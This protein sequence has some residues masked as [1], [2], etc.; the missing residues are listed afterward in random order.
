MT[1][2]LADFQSKTELNKYPVALR[3]RGGIGYRMPDG[4]IVSNFVGHAIHYKH[5]N[6]WLPITLAHNNGNF[7]G[8]EY[9]WNGFAVTYKKKVLFTP[10][11]ITFNGV[12]RP[13]NFFLDADRNSLIAYIPN[14]GEYQILF[15][16]AGVKEILTIPEPLEGLLTFQVAHETKPSEIYKTERHLVGG[17]LTGDSYMLTAD[18]TYPLVIDP[19]YADDTG[20]GYV[21]G[22]S[23]VYTTA[24]S[25]S[26]A[27]N[28]DVASEYLMVGQYYNG[29]G[30][31]IG[32]MYLK[33]ATAGIPDTDIV[34]Q[35]NLKMCV[36]YDNSIVDFDV[37]I[38]KHDWS[39][40]DPLTI[41]NREAAYDN[42]LAATSDDNIWRNTAGITLNTQ[43][44]S[45]NLS[46]AWVNKTGY[47]YY[48]LIS[49]RDISA[50]APTGY[51][52]INPYSQDSVT[53]GYRPVLTVVHGAAS[54][55]NGNFFAFF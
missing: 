25:T 32:R 21:T 18:M 30:Y 8:S 11:S 9:G 23:S 7:E 17:S 3:T 4:S 15:T 27:Y 12:V 14:I 41:T 5:G 55:G 51:E 31:S 38:R 36:E 35:V 54:A 40:Q 37:V 2:W 44:A 22:W 16:G 48:S 50:T 39:A 19:D 33:F 49:S 29:T 47:T 26:D 13:L 6:E 53:V 34:S 1:T 24:R 43:Y 45:G 10:Q 52:R 42:C 28:P 46:T 20:D